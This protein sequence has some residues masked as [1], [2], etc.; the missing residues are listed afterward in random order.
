MKLV[1]GDDQH[2]TLARD[3]RKARGCVVHRRG[4]HGRVVRSKRRLERMSAGPVEG[5]FHDERVWA[6]RKINISRG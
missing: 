2:A 4:V 3:E 6:R 1:G 5:H